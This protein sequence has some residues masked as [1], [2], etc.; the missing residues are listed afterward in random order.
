MQCEESSQQLLWHIKRSSEIYSFSSNRE[1]A[2]GSSPGIHYEKIKTLLSDFRNFHANRDYKQNTRSEVS[3]SKRRKLIYRE[4]NT[5]TP[6]FIF[7][8][9]RTENVVPAPVLWLPAISL[10]RTWYQHPSFRFQLSDYR[11]RGTSTRPFVSNYQPTENVVPA[12]VLSFPTI[13]LPRTWY[14]HPS[15]GFQLSAH[16]EHST[17]TFFSYLTFT[18]MLLMCV[19]CADESSKETDIPHGLTLCSHFLPSLCIF[20]HILCSHFFSLIYTTT[21]FGLT[22][23]HQV[24]KMLAWRNMLSANTLFCCSIRSKMESRTAGSFNPAYYAPD[25][26]QL[27]RNM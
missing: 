7:N 18:H 4:R 10:P 26:G 13:N 24:R 14:Q 27:G 1:A 8:Y 23:H 22:G 19:H 9:Q 5:T 16:R 12:P 6:P 3:L 21:C 20:V 25:G 2:D 11:E 15:F 17:I